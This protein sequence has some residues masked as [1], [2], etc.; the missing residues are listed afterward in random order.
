MEKAVKKAIDIE[1]KANLQLPLGIREIN[2]R[3]LK[4]YILAKKD[5]NKAN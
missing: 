1:A 2:F 3:Y 4:S 5:K